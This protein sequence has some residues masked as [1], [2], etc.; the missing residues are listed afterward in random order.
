MEDSKSE[1][2]G[3]REH[4]LSCPK[5]RPNI[6]DKVHS[7]IFDHPSRNIFVGNVDCGGSIILGDLL[8]CFS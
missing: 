2:K 5:C 4:D 8:R 3:D 1:M 6:L 7:F